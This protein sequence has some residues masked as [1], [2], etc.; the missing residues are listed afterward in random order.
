MR[1]KS[2]YL[3][4][5]SIMTGLT[6]LRIL[7]TAGAAG[8]GRAISGAFIDAGARIHV[9]DMDQQAIAECNQSGNP[10]DRAVYSVADVAD[11]NAVVDVMDVQR[12]LMGGLDVLV[13]CAGIKGPTAPVESM[14]LVDWQRCIAVNLDA[15]FL[16]CKHAVPM[17]RESESAGIINISSTAGWHGYPLRTPYAAS[18]WGLIG[19]TKSLAM[20]LG[21]AG[22]RVNAICPGSVN[23]ER[24]D[25][26]IADEAVETGLSESEVRSRYTRGCSL[27]SFVDAEDIADTVLF[28]ASRASR[29]ITGQ[30]ISVDG[31]LESFGGLD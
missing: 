23:G 3:R 22:I 17:L 18:K 9:V 12:R 4:F 19:L 15:A 25:R 13:N 5:R 28:L 16:C 29:R 27:R 30:A 26:V 1:A 7:I 6:D 21:P 11:E 8:I 14:R 2:G 10:P 31:H 24:M 20:E